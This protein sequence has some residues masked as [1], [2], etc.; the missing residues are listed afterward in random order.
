LGVNAFVRR[1]RLRASRTRLA[2]GAPA[3]VGVSGQKRAAWLK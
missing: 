1:D 3:S 2:D